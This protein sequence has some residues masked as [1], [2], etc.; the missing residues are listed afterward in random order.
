MSARLSV[1][2]PIPVAANPS[3]RQHP[4]SPLPYCTRVSLRHAVVA[5]EDD[6]A[7]EE[8]DND[9]DDELE[10]VDVAVRVDDDL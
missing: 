5:L 3:S 7:E 6:V 2:Q 9:K 8:A 10:E 1:L 4:H